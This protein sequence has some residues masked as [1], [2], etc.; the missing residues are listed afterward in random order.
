[1]RKHLNSQ[2]FKGSAFVEMDSVAEAEALLAKELVHE[3][4]TLVRRVACG[5][6]ACTRFGA[7]RRHTPRLPESRVAGGLHGAQEG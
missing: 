3:G 4:A 7:L 6:A 1:M 2:D 5:A